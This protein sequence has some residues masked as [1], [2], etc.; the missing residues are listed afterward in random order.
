[1]LQLIGYVA[2]NDALGKAFHDGGLPYPGSPMS[3]ELFLVR[4]LGPASGGGFIVTADNGVE[5]AIAG[6]FGQ[7]N[8]IALEGLILGFGSGSVT[9]CVPRMD[10]RAFRMASCV[11]PARPDGGKYEL[12]ADGKRVTCSVHGSAHTPRGPAPAANSPTGRLM[13]SSAVRPRP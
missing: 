13:A 7:V 4:R 10:T 3:A 1:M 12:S 5:F 9:R 8:G 2:L 6:G 11:A